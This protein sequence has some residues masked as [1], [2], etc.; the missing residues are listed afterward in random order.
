[1][2]SRLD[3]ARQY[4]GH[5]EIVSIAAAMLFDGAGERGLNCFESLGGV[6]G[7]Q[8]SR[9]NAGIHHGLE[10][11]VRVCEPPHLPQPLGRCFCEPGLLQAS[12]RL[13]RVTEAKEGRSRRKT[14]LRV[15]VLLYGLEHHSKAD[16][17]FL[18]RP[19]SEAKAPAAVEHSVRLAQKC[20][21]PRQMEHAEV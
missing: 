18:R 13:L 11:S 3:S 9:A 4:G 15:A 21:R 19:D 7:Q 5:R 20:I 16:R 12:D 2:G 8:A 6:R 10:K 1:T 17:F 14:D